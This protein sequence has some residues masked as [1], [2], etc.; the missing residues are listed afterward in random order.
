VGGW[1][2]EAGLEWTTAERRSET[3]AIQ[4]RIEE[5]EIPKDATAVFRVR[6]GQA[7]WELVH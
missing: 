7:A 5:G 3:V 1:Q 6:D 4:H 2:I